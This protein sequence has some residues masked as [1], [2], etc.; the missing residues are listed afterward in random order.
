MLM[1]IKRLISG[2]LT[3]VLAVVSL[4]VTAYATDNADIFAI[5]PNGTELSLEEA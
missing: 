5:T 1:T 4:S 3:L 2:V